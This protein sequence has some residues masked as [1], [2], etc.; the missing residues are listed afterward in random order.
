MTQPLFLNYCKWNS[1][2]GGTGNFLVGT[3]AATD[4]A[5]A[6]DIPQNCSAINGK[7]YRYYAQSADGSQTELGRGT[8]SSGTPQLA[9]TQVIA[10]SDGTT[11]PVN[12]LTVPIVDLFPTPP[13]SMETV[14]A[15]P[16]GTY[17]V[18]C[19]TTAPP[20]WTKDFSFNDRALKITTG[21]VTAGGSNFYSAVMA[22]TVVGSDTPTASKM[23]SHGHT[24]PSEAAAGSGPIGDFMQAD[25]TG[26]PGAIGTSFA[27]GSN[28]H[29]HTILMDMAYLSMIL[30]V[31]N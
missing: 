24:V 17:M 21:T 18:F 30:A 14:P 23:F 15:F 22:Q 25:G 27:G 1:L 10:N 20:G 28:A 3:A 7:L 5:G 13:V 16:S 2:T 19:N 8:Y 6:H 11:T 4:N 31:K 26:S 9:R 12:F 29:N